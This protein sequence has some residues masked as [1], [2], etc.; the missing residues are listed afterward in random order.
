MKVTAACAVA[1]ASLATLPADAALF[2]LT[3]DFNGA[4]PG[5][6][7]EAVIS[8]TLQGDGNTVV[9]DAV[10]DFATF[11][12]IAGPSLPFIESVDQ[13]TAH[14]PGPLDPTLTLDG[15]FADIVA[16]TDP[17]TADGFAFAVANVY[18]TL[19]VASDIYTSGSGFGGAFTPF[20]VS[21]YSL[22][23]LAT[24][25]PATLALAASG[26]GL[27]GLVRARTRRAIS[28]RMPRQN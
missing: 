19:G 15:S 4:D 8:G 20:V 18:A 22:V 26:L 12:G 21:G 6:V 28:G 10:L 11:D 13:F 23:P 25:V 3:Y 17:G 1:V 24:P 2:N 7:L 5:G 27:L 14:H 16:A 9:V